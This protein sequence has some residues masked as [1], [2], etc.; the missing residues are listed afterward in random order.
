MHFESIC[1]SA[2]REHFDVA[3]VLKVY[4]IIASIRHIN[5][6]GYQKYYEERI[7]G[8]TQY[9]NLMLTITPETLFFFIKQNT[10][11]QNKTDLMLDIYWVWNS[12]RSKAQK[13]S[14]HMPM[15]EHV[16]V[17]RHIKYRTNE[18]SLLTNHYNFVNTKSMTATE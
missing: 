9:A 7:D 10:S 12:L 5:S 18:E 8:Y 17:F 16:V 13:L 1:R 4:E 14:I 11:E 3:W 2:A 6:T 15:S